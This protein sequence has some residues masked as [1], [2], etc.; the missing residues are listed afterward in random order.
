[1]KRRKTF[2]GLPPFL[3][4]VNGGLLDS[5]FLSVDDVDA[6]GQVDL[7]GAVDAAADEEL[8]A[9]VVN[10]QGAVAVNDEAAVGSAHAGL[11]AVVGH[12][13]ADAVGESVGLEDFKVFLVED[14]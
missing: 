9:D 8:S 14:E 13:L 1:M 12:G 11:A 3:W 6:L 5:H 2:E 7:G 10:A 4:I